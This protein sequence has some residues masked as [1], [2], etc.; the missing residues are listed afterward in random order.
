VPPSHRSATSQTRPFRI[1][2]LVLDPERRTAERGGKFVALEPR[3]FDVLVYLAGQG[4]RVV[5]KDELLARIW[6]DR[7]VTDDA[8]YRAIRMARDALGPEGTQILQ[9]VHGRGYRCTAERRSPAVGRGR[10]PWN[11]SRMFAGAGFLLLLIA[12][13]WFLAGGPDLQTNSLDARP[14][15]VAVIPFEPGSAAPRA[16]YL[17]PALAAELISDLGRVH[18]IDVLGRASTFSAARAEEPDAWAELGAR[19]RISGSWLRTGDELAV[20]VEIREVVGERLIWSRTVRRPWDQLPE[21]RAELAR[22]VARALTPTHRTLSET[23]F[24]APETAGAGAYDLFLQARHL[25]RTREPK[26]LDRAAELLQQALARAPDFALAH[27]ALA[28]VYL[29]LPSWQAIGGD[30]SRQLAYA[31]AREALRLDPRLGEAR[32]ILAQEAREG[33]RWREA[34]RL[35]RQ[36]LQREPGNPTLAQWYAE[37]LLLAGRID[38]ARESARRAVALDPMAPMPR[39][40]LA[41]SA[42]IGGRNELA[43]GE[44]RRAVDLGLTSTGIVAAWA[45][46]R[47]GRERDAARWLEDL[48]RPSAAVEPCRLA[49]LGRTSADA[50]LEAM[51]DE[52]RRDDLAVIYHLVCA[53][54]LNGDE[55]AIELLEAAPRSMAFAI[56]WAPEFDRLRR[57]KAFQLLLE[58]SDLEAFRVSEET[59]GSGPPVQAPAGA[60]RV[61]PR[62]SRGDNRW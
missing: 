9:T 1:G 38:E 39:T 24:P 40:V 28:S 11:F 58:V 23:Y 22:G 34:E 33:R 46:H 32:A 41:W 44:A 60:A 51:V 43:L 49:V 7:V 55:T 5:S 15:A 6:A 61:I 31:A 42:V 18:G 56:L 17:G 53:A 54:M 62:P 19:T 13:A 30:P 29:V 26:K 45:A 8:V 14:G 21:L 12:V 10:V 36:A 57:G 4:G 47:L 25:W 35:Y 20:H 59:A 52:P 3:A 37:F 27:E 50:A 48:L 2:E 16:P